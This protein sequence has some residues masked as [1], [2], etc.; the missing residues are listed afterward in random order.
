MSSLSDIVAITI[1]RETKVPSQ[2][3]F[4]WVNFLDSNTS[5]S[6]GDR[7]R[8]YADDDEVN[9]DGDVSAEAKKFSAIYFAQDNAPTKLY[10][11]MVDLTAPETYPDALN[12]AVKVDDD[13]YGVAAD[14]STVAEQEAIAAWVETRTKMYGVASSDTNILDSTDTTNIAY[15]LD[16][17]SYDRSWVFYSSDRA[18]DY[19]EAAPFGRQFPLTPGSSQW[20]YKTFSGVAADSLTSDEKSDALGFNAN[21]YTERGGINVFEK[22]TTASGEWIDVIHGID[23]IVSNVESEIFGK[24]VNS[25]K[26]PYTQ[27]GINVIVNAVR[28]ILRQ[29]V[30]N[31]FLA[32]NPAFTVTAPDLSDISSANKGNR[33]LPD[34]EFEATLAGAIIKTTIKGRI[35]L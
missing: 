8:S 12:D 35:V 18:S 21:V 7:I 19:P 4:G 25:E 15:S 14:T 10:I 20:A 9:A 16:N 13:W 34:V 1:S 31:G 6:G 17:S 3:G 22:G 24:L 29:A 30:T 33:L 32:A 11:T 28:T 26:I 23:W 2:A 5:F 27:Q